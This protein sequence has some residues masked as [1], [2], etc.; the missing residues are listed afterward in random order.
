LKTTDLA[1]AAT[2]TGTGIRQSTVADCRCDSQRRGTEEEKS[3]WARRAAR[4]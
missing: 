2:A 4:V 3:G 1:A